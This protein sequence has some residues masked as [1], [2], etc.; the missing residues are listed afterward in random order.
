MFIIHCGINLWGKSLE[1]KGGLD[2][3]Y[4]AMITGSST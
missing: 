3:R 1:N 2:Y 4:L